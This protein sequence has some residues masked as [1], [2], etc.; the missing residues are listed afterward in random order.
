MIDLTW[1]CAQGPVVSSRPIIINHQ[2]HE[3]PKFILI[4]FLFFSSCPK[5]IAFCTGVGKVK[6]DLFVRKE[7]YREFRFFHGRLARWIK[8]RACDVGE[9]KEG[10]ENKLWRRWSNGRVWE[11]AVTYIKRRNGWI[12]S[13]DVGEVYGKV[14]EWALLY[15]FITMSSAHSPTFLS[16]H[17]RHNSFSNPFVALPTSQL[18]L[19]PFRRFT[20]VTANSPTLPLLHICRSSFSNPSFASPTSQALHLILLA[21]RPWILLERFPNFS[22]NERRIV[23][24]KLR[25]KQ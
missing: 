4:V 10:L 13:S 19:Q 7:E 2:Y 24:P 25:N 21:S 16:H 22:L 5:N 17:L 6:T 1:E 12:M 11:W 20:Y 18:I 8:W 9:A 15:I 23:L 3:L 14:G